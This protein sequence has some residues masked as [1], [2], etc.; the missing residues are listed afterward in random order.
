M[1]EIIAS[2]TLPQ[3]SKA[4]RA[5]L[6]DAKNSLV[7]EEVTR[8]L[9]DDVRHRLQIFVGTVNRLANHAA[10]PS[11]IESEIVGLMISYRSARVSADEATA[12]TREYT[13]V[14]D[15]FPIWAIREGFRRIKNAEIDGISL[16]F[17]PAAPRLKSVVSDVM[18]PLLADRYDAKRVL[19]TRIAPAENPAMAARVNRLTKAELLKK[20]GPNFGIGAPP[21]PIADAKPKPRQSMT[22]EQ[23]VAHYKAHNLSFKPKPKRD[24]DRYGDRYDD[25]TASD[26]EAA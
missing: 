23:L 17:P 5:A 1:Q 12:I 4:D 16:D 8:P 7:G 3:I 13:A 18:R 25:V 14:L 6:I 9:P 2:S 15:Q 21:A 11:Q 20:Y 19:D 26:G 24:E 22:P 10:A